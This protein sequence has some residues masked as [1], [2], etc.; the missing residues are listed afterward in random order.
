MHPLLLGILCPRT[1][2][3][4]GFPANS[5]QVGS[6]SLPGKVNITKGQRMKG[7]ACAFMKCQGHSYVR[8]AQGQ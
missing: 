3:L 1:Y 8:G 5:K 7:H 2:E 4:V 6:H